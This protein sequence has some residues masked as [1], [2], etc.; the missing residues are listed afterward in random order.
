MGTMEVRSEG[1]KDE[2]EMGKE[3]G[4]ICGFVDWKFGKE[5]V[6]TY[7]SSTDETDQLGD[8]DQTNCEH[9]EKGLGVE[10]RNWV[11]VAVGLGAIVSSVLVGLR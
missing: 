6:G 10:V 1:R 5:L 3:G 7:S 11:V 9:S 2:K 8:V 4:G